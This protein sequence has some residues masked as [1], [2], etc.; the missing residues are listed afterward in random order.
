M[1]DGNNDN[2]KSILDHLTGALRIGQYLI[3][4]LKPVYALSNFLANRDASSF[5]QVMDEWQDPRAT[6]ENIRTA[7]GSSNQ[8][9]RQREIDAHIRGQREEPTG[10][11][12]VPPEDRWWTG[13]QQP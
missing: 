8:D 9:Q 7:I 11:T 3:P 6:W 4:E 5:G 12:W 13:K 10:R 2:E 1:S